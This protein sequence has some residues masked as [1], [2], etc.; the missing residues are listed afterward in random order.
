VPPYRQPEFLQ[1]E[2]E[3]RHRIRCPIHG[4][5]HFSVNERRVIDHPLFRRLRY[6]RQ[7][8][9]TELIYPGATH[10]RFEHSLGVMEVASRAFDRLAERRGDL[11]EDTFK[12]VD[13]LQE[14][15]LAVAR[16]S[17]RLA[18]LLHDVGHTS[19][20]HAAEAVLLAEEQGHEAMGRGIVRERDLLGGLLEETFPHCFRVIS[21]ILEGPP[22][23]PPQ[24]QI[25]TDLVS[26]QLDADRTDYLLRDSHHCGVEYGLF[27]HRRMI[28]CLE[29]ETGD[30]SELDIAI[31]RDGLQTFEALILARYQMNATVYQHR[32]RRLYDEYLRRYIVALGDDAP[33]TRE[34]LL[35]E[36]DVTML[37][38]MS[39]DVEEDRGERTIWANRILNR[40][41]H[42]LVHETGLN[43]DAM[44]IG[45]SRRVFQGLRE[46][47]PAVDFIQDRGSVAIHNLLIPGDLDDENR[48]KFTLVSRDGAGRQVAEESQILGKIPRTLQRALIFADA[49]G[50]NPLHEEMRQV[51]SQIWRE[52]GGR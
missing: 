38:R 10:S 11:M 14:K 29:L 35:R 52:Q 18:A 47:F 36:T 25:L 2:D 32:L 39:K 27:D 45:R 28:E 12:Q 19:F 49:R 31:N 8:A 41:H 23:L 17:L 9:L 22:D 51:A 40:D 43:A 30:D 46:R 1:P 4:F 20:S 15:P 5:I 44:D 7:L 16:Q 48:I 33:R 21:L 42:R 50:N 3:P 6:I 34:Q 26:G 24:L 37:A 13:G